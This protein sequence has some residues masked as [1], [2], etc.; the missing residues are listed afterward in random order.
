MGVG[1]GRG[2]GVGEGRGGVGAGCGS[3]VTGGASGA[4]GEAG[5]TVRAARRRAVRTASPEPSGRSG[6]VN[7]CGG[8]TT[9][10]GG[11]AGFTTRGV[12]AARTSR[13]E[14]D[15]KVALHRYP[16]V[17]PAATSALSRSASNEIRTRMSIGPLP[18]SIGVN[19]GLR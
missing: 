10:F 15:S 3:G 1:V 2:G 9:V 5:P 19:I 16:E 17:T 6:V 18:D 4:V 14:L 7:W 11:G 8:M 12:A 13:G